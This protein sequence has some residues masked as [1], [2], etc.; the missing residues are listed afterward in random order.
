MPMRFNFIKR[1]AMKK[2]KFE[3]TVFN[4]NLIRYSLQISML[5]N[6]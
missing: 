1:G 3:N 6:C 2:I 4:E 5:L